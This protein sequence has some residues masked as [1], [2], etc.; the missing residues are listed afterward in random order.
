MPCAARI[1]TPWAAIIK[2]LDNP[3]C[4]TLDSGK[5]NALD[6]PG[7]NDL[8]GQKFNA[9]DGPRLDDLISKAIY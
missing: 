8:D 9:S 3:K 4:N 6:G 2:A 1:L 7:L 5:F